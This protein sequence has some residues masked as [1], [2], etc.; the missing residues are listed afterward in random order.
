MSPPSMS[1]LSVALSVKLDAVDLL[2]SDDVA[3]R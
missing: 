1:R 3:R 2:V